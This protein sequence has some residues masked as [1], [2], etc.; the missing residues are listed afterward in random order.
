MSSTNVGTD[1]WLQTNDTVSSS[2]TSPTSTTRFRVCWRTLARSSR[3]FDKMLFGLFVESQPG[4]GVEWEVKLAG[5]ATSAMNPFL[6]LL[7]SNVDSF[8][9]LTASQEIKLAA[10]YSLVAAADKY[11]CL[12]LLK[13]FANQCVEDLPL[14]TGNGMDLHRLAWIYYQLGCESGYRQVSTRLMLHFSTSKESAIPSPLPPNLDSQ[15]SKSRASSWYRASVLQLGRLSLT[16]NR[17]NVTH[18]RTWIIS[19]LLGDVGKSI[20]TLVSGGGDRNFCKNNVFAVAD[21]K[22]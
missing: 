4:L 17:D 15:Y 19:K 13:P 3:V 8:Q 22:D 14:Q 5:D 20:Q 11:D 6:E 1:L 16:M 2:P 18:G 12:H 7:H 21:S 10:V 9:G